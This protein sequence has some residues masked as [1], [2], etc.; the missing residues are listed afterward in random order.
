MI[1][2]IIGLFVLSWAWIA[3]DLITAPIYPDNYPNKETKDE[4]KT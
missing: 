2:W 3:W 4:K 1:W